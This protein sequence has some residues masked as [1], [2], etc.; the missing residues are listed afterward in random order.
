MAASSN[1]TSTKCV[2]SGS[3][4]RDS[5]SRP[6]SPPPEHPTGAKDGDKGTSLLHFQYSNAPDPPSPQ[7]DPLLREIET[8][9]NNSEQLPHRLKH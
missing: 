5:G 2:H 4:S 8:Q 3:T 9:Y 6:L 1:G 7:N